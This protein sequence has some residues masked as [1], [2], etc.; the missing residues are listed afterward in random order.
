[1]LIVNMAVNNLFIKI[2]Y[3]NSPV[4]ICMFCATYAKNKM[5][6]K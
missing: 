3:N 2:H 4:H 1:M 5:K 6:K